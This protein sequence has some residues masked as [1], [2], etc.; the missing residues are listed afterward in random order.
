M[1]SM[2]FCCISLV[3][4]YHFYRLLASIAGTWTF[5]KKRFFTLLGKKQR[6]GLKTGNLPL[7]P[8][9]G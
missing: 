6:L 4:I 5:D 3:S 9:P 7:M 1:R 8:C 2:L